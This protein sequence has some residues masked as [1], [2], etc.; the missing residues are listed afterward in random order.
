MKSWLETAELKVR[1][2][3]LTVRELSAK[4]TAEI[5][6]YSRSLEKAVDESQLHL[7][8]L[9]E[10]ARRSVVGWEAESVEDIVVNVPTSVLHAVSDRLQGFAKDDSKNSEPVQSEGSSTG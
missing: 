8:T 5:R 7:R 3:T 9:A 2:Q 4:E 6:E 1:G 10:A